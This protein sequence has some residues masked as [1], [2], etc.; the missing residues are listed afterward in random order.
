MLIACV[1]GCRCKVELIFV[2]FNN[3]ILNLNS[4]KPYNQLN[5]G[6]KDAFI[7]KNTN[8]LSHFLYSTLYSIN[9]NLSHVFLFFFF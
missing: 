7:Y 2:F 4:V 3:L 8:L 1:Y 9:H 5:F 6:V